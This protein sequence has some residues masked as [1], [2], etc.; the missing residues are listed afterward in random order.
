MAEEREPRQRH[1][2]E[3]AS[4]DGRVGEA[5]EELVKIAREDHARRERAP[6]G[7]RRRKGGAPQRPLPPGER[8]AREV[9]RGG[10]EAVGLGAPQALLVRGLLT[11]HEL[12]DGEAECPG[13]WHEQRNAR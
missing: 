13:E 6:D 2:H 3:E 11:G 12:G 9:E 8:R 1:E 5:R 10:D 7:D 4:G